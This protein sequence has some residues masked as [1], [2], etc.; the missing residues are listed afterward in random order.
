MV[1][2]LLLTTKRT[3]ICSLVVVVEKAVNICGVKFARAKHQLI[4]AIPL[5][6]WKH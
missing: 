4:H 6:L 1:R 2:K 5:A 3:I